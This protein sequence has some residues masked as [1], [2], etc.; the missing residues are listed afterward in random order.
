MKAALCICRVS[1]TLKVSMKM[2]QEHEALRA[3]HHSMCRQLEELLGKSGNDASV[4]DE[5]PHLW[6]CLAYQLSLLV[7]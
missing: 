2:S 3:E 5:V 4:P 6:S 7:V 1:E